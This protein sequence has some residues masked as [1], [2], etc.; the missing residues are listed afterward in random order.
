M[1]PQEDEKPTLTKADEPQLVLPREHD[2]LKYVGELFKTYIIAEKNGKELLLIDKHAAHERILYEKLKS[3]KAGS[4]AQLLLQ[5][6]TVTLGKEEY[7][8]AVT[9]LDMFS[10]CSFEVEDFGDGTVIVRSAPQ[11]LDISEISDCVAEMAGYI[12]LGK[13]DIYTEKMEW[14]YANV[15]CRSAIKAGNNNTP[16]ELEDILRQLE[17]N[18]QIKYCPHGRPVCISMTKAEIEKQFGRT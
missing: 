6:V 11:Y 9:H 12:A 7:T 18:T 5:P 8:A 2:A 14:F 3:E 10:E 15:A 13:N 1:P 16:A 4:S 17:Q